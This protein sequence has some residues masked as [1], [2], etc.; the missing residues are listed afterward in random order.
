MNT[1]Y[2][3][4]ILLAIFICRQCSTS[5][6]YRGEEMDV[7]PSQQ[8]V[9]KNIRGLKGG[10]NIALLIGTD[11]YKSWKPLGNPVHDVVAIQS[12]L[13]D[14]YGYETTVLTNPPKDTII[15]HLRL[16]NDNFR[17][18]KYG[19]NTN[20]VIF[21]AGHGSYDDFSKGYLVPTDAR[22][23]NSD[24]S[25]SSYIEYS[26][27]K[28]QIAEIEAT[29][30]LFALDV[31]NGGTFDALEIG[32]KKSYSTCSVANER[33]FS[34]MLLSEYI[35]KYN[36][37]PSRKFIASGGNENV[38]D[39]KLGGHSP[40]AQEFI[41]LLGKNHE[42]KKVTEFRHLCYNIYDINTS[43]AVF[44]DFSSSHGGG[45]FLF[46]PNT[47]E[48]DDVVSTYYKPVQD[49][50]GHT[51]AASRVKVLILPRQNVGE[52]VSKSMDEPAMRF[53]IS[54]LYDVLEKSN[55]TPLHFDFTSASN[56]NDDKQEIVKKSGAD[57]Y[58]EVD[59]KTASDGTDAYNVSVTLNCIE[60]NG[61]KLK[62]T[63]T[64]RG[65]Y[66]RTD[67]YEALAE[68]ALE[69]HTEEIVNLTLK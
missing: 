14:K 59:L 44:S 48:K 12:I 15:K 47:I 30:I 63:K 34:K 41:N 37:C 17:Q 64:Y 40:F 13:R 43:K 25:R 19:T 21:I 11:T 68:K 22:D 36:S 6:Q 29:H 5:A 39:G 7:I 42:Y 18:K 32:N 58:I 69:E 24:I 31:C 62:Y 46:I 23:P 52:P 1:R 50:P 66:F 28:T 9:L 61:G 35:S 38:S 51:T 4:L 26:S 8:P 60:V 16:L 54:Y 55:F 33:E 20:L 3:Q 10:K 49:L 45:D 27:I 57:V 2:L 67:D 53:A 65:P 56:V